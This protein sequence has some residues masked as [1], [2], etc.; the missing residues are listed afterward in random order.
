[1]QALLP[2]LAAARRAGPG[3]AILGAALTLSAC[4]A[5]GVAVG[6]TVLDTGTPSGTAGPQ[7]LSSSQWLAGEFAITSG[8][9]NQA[10]QLSAYLTQGLSEVGATFTFD[11]Y[12]SSGFTARSA[13]RPAPLFTATATFTGD[14]WNVASADWTPTATGDYWLALQVSSSTMSPGLDAPVE[15][16]ASTGP[17]PALGFAYT[18]SSGQYTTSGAAP[19]GLDITTVTTGGATD[20]PLPPWALGALGVALAGLTARRRR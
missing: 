8:E 19:I 12:A 20:A 18:N 16:S 6:A 4:C 7:V 13:S 5:G 11:I 9:A 17:D 10:Y 2:T 15:S 3:R 14:G 1:M